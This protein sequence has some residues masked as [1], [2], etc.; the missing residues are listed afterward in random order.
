MDINKS[1]DE[2]TSDLAYR[3]SCD[4]EKPTTKG[5]K[6]WCNMSNPTDTTIILKCVG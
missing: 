6:V 2:N 1:A 3:V 5:E 4:P